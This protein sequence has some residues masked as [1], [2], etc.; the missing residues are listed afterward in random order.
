MRTRGTPHYLCYVPGALVRGK[1]TGHS[2]LPRGQEAEN[3]GDGDDGGACRLQS[4][5]S[6]V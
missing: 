4:E 2:L 3:V 6:R 1:Q 5:P